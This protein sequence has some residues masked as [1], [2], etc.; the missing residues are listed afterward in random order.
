[1][2]NPQ[3]NDSSTNGIYLAGRD[4]VFPYRIGHQFDMTTGIASYDQREGGY[5][6]FL[7]SCTSLRR[8]LFDL[9]THV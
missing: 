5:L 4:R 8:F 1:M 2:K 7:S 6:V 3:A 9:Y